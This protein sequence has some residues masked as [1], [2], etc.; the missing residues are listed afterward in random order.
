MMERAWTIIAG[1]CLIVAAVFLF[2]DNINAAFVVATLGVVA[3]FLRLRDQM[4]KRITPDESVE[5]EEEHNSSGDHD[6]D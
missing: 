2:Q 1:A 4:R 3:W 5:A 6:D